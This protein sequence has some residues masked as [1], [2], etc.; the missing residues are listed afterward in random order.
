MKAA[1]LGVGLIG[2]SLALGLKE[3]TSCRV[4]GYDRSQEALDWAVAA[5]VIDEGSQ[6][7]ESVVE[8]ANFIF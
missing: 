5:G 4:S 7:L 6:R 8:D 1:V 2:G 3:R